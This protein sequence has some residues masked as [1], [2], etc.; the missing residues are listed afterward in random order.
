MLDK[1]RVRESF[2]KS[3]RTYEKEA[4]LQK[5]LADELFARAQDLSPGTVLDIGCGTGYL[6]DRLAGRFPAA[7]V[8]GIDT[9][10]GMI[11]MAGKKYLRPNLNFLAGDG[12]NIHFQD[13]LFDLVV[14]NASFQWMDVKKVFPE[15]ARILAPGGDLLF[16]TF[17]P[18][19]LR[20]LKAAGFRV[21]VFPAKEELQALLNGRFAEITLT[22]RGRPQLFRSV[23]DLI[24][25]L[26]GIGAETTEN[27]K[28]PGF[29]VFKAFGEYKK[30]CGSSA[31][32]TATYEVIFGHYKKH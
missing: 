21:N 11:K 24:R 13:G 9:A 29:D 4:V 1:R 18:G 27:D 7:D 2:S 20:E 30:H 19:T 26:H 22:S 28:D 23:R 6:A 25:H 5:Q 32:V 14:A 12:E 15:A 3:A 10:V 17:G 8:F 16:H 31:G